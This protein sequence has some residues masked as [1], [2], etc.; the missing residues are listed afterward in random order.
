MILCYSE[1][2]VVLKKQLPDADQQ[3]VQDAE[4]PTAQAAIDKEGRV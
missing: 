1:I 4:I 3:A 2:N